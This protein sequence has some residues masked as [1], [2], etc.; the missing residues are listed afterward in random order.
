M[1]KLFLYLAKKLR[2]STGCDAPFKDTN[3]I[4]PLS[5]EA[6]EWWNTVNKCFD[7][8]KTVLIKKD[9]LTYKLLVD[10]SW[11][12]SENDEFLTRQKAWW[13]DVHTMD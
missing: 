1:K 3:A 10:A 9:G 2:L 7:L 11:E 5:P 4:N 12:P 6:F 13:E 8:K